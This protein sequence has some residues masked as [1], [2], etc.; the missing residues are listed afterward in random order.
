MIG[1]VANYLRAEIML[2]FK[3]L[4]PIA[5]GVDFYWLRS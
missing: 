5:L 2:F 4:T 1:I 3:E